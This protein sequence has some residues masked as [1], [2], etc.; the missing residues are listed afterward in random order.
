MAKCKD[1]NN[2]HYVY[3]M[4]MFSTAYCK[5]GITNKIKKRRESIQNGCPLP[6]ILIAL[7]EF[8]SREQALSFER[9]ILEKYRKH[10]VQ[11]EWF[12][13]PE[14][15]SCENCFYASYDYEEECLVCHIEGSINKEIWGA[16]NSGFC[17]WTGDTK[18]C[19]FWRE[20]FRLNRALALNETEWEEFSHQVNDGMRIDLYE[21]ECKRRNIDTVVRRAGMRLYQPILLQEVE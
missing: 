17:D 13:I 10:K 2:A 4:R 20:A 1:N 15:C 9:H 21:R 19:A 14:K 5:I 7:E 3:L 6:L 8:G 16:N 18:N 12:F 11:G